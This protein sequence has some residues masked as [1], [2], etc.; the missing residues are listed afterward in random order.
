MV[1]Q[2]RVLLVDDE[3]ELRAIFAEILRDESYA[4]D[5]ARSVGEARSFLTARTYDLVV[6]DWRLPDGDG[7]SVAD[8]A[9]ELGAKT[10]VMSGYLSRLPGGRAQGHE[11]LMKPVR[12]SDFVDLVRSSIG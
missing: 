4:V 11:T 5:L 9:S 7:I 1:M 6:V 12:L 3:A 8:W 10:F 2:K